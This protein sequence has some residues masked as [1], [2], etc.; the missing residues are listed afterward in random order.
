MNIW[1]LIGFPFILADIMLIF[2][3]EHR[4]ISGWYLDDLVKFILVIDFG[5]TFYL[6]YRVYILHQVLIPMADQQAFMIVM[7]LAGLS[8]VIVS[9]NFWRIT[10]CCLHEEKC[11]GARFD[12]L[13]MLFSYIFLAMISLVC[14]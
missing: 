12:L 13:Y 14:G 7:T 5:V 8:G 11:S 4:K 10:R 6:F 2:K 9:M 1:Y 3:M